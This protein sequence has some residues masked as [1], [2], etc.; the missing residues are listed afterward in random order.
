MTSDFEEARR[1]IP[2]GVNSPVRAFTGLGIDPVFIDRGEGRMLF[3]RDGKSYLDFCL[4]WGSLLL[5]HAFPPVIDEV[6]NAL[7]KGTSFG[8][9]TTLETK[10]ARII[11][12]AVPSCERIRFVNSGT[13]ALMTAIRIAR[14]FTG[15]D[16]ILKFDGCYHGHSDSL[17]VSAGSG[18][19]GLSSASSRGV[20]ASVVSNT[21]SV[22]FNDEAAFLRALDA[23]GESIALVV[24]EPVPA[25][26]GLVPP[27]AGILEFLRRETERRGILL[28][29]DEVITGFRVMFGGVQDRFAVRPDLTC[30]GKIIGGG[31]PV[32]AVGGRKDLMDLLAPAGPVYQA[33]TLSGNPIAMTAG[34]TTLEYLSCNQGV[35]ANME[36][37]VSS[38]AERLRGSIPY[39]V[40]SF[41]PM[42]TIFT[43]KRPMENFDDAQTQDKD[44]FASAFRRMLGK[45]IYMPPSRFE[46]AFVS[47]M[48]TEADMDT[49]FSAVTGAFEGVE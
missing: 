29:F 41:G 31:F 1:W 23:T 43:A 48:H 25:N 22:P 49:L 34:I 33:G 47:A 15:R 37:L 45:G 44:A 20:P 27:K 7:R 5:G 26:M 42:F 36:K 6:T 18:V 24:V 4:S 35:Y 8:A 12:G 2:G 11:C 19:A 9:P 32:G 28:C 17:L 14:G 16:K 38:F 46:T 40:N 30:F 10:L 21:V 3:D 39:T 13:E